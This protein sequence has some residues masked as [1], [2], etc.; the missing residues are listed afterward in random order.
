MLSISSAVIEDIKNMREATPALIAYYYFDYKDASKRDLRSLLTLLLFQLASNPGPCWD[1]LYK[2]CIAC[3]DGSER[4]SDAALAKCLKTMF[5]LSEQLPIFVIM[6]ALDECPNT[7][8]TLSAREEVLDLV[9]DLVGSSQPNLFIC[10]TSRPE[11]DIQ[12]V[13]NLQGFNKIVSSKEYSQT[14]D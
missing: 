5:G 13:L 8:G 12:T 10:V 4:P 6:D 1:I 11:Q 7:T 9:E 3:D 14:F 2:L